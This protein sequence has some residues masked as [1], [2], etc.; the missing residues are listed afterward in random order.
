MLQSRRWP[1]SGVRFRLAT[2]M[3]AFSATP[4]ARR[5][6]ALQEEFERDASCNQVFLV[7]TVGATLI[8]T[9]GL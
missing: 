4:E 8:A 9:L 1:H 2:G 5:L 3:T 6:E 7:L